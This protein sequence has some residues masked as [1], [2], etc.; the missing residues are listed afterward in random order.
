LRPTEGHEHRFVRPELSAASMT[1]K[2]RMRWHCRMSLRPLFRCQDGILWSQAHCQRRTT[3]VSWHLCLLPCWRLASWIRLQPRI[4]MVTIG[5][6]VT[7]CIATGGTQIEVLTRP[8]AIVREGRGASAAGNQSFQV[9][10][11]APNARRGAA[12]QCPHP[13]RGNIRLLEVGGV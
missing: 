3:C 8:L 6:A 1:R 12:D 9:T 4:G 2:V 10:P 5:M 7:I 11:S 13:Q